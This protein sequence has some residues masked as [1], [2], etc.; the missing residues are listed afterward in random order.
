MTVRRCVRAGAKNGASGTIKKIYLG[1]VLLSIL[2]NILLIL[3]KLMI[4]S[5]GKTAVGTYSIT[6]PRNLKKKEPL[7][8]IASGYPHH[9]HTGWR[10]TA[11][12][13]ATAS[14]GVDLDI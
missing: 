8:R 13:T 11:A 12:A 1:K 9:G 6:V 14:A 3:Y 2:L 7:G 4:L 10:T 5:R